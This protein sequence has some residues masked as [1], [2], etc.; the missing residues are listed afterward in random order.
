MGTIISILIVIVCLL[1]IIVVLIQNSKGGGISS[2][3]GASNQMM[4]VKKTA[5]TVEKITWGLAVA[6]LFLSIISTSFN[7]PQGAVKSTESVTRQKATE[8]A[9]IEAPVNNAVPN[10]PAQQAPAP[11][12]N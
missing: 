11:A 10:I 2:S 6:L 4:G 3:F 1:L 5:E 9:P 8:A 7:K 12:G